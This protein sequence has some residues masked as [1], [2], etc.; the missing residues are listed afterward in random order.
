MPF[1]PEDAVVRNIAFNAILELKKHDWSAENIE[2]FL[3]N[4]MLCKGFWGLT[5]KEIDYFI[6]LAF[7]HPE[8]VEKLLKVDFYDIYTEYWGSGIFHLIFPATDELK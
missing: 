6:D 5:E 2:H 3:K 7:N 4:T 8:V 1:H